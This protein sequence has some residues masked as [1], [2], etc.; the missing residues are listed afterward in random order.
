MRDEVGPELPVAD[1]SDRGDRQLSSGRGRG[2]RAKS[3]VVE[4]HESFSLTPAQRLLILDS[5][6]RS[7]LSAH[8]FGD[9]V[10]V[11]GH[12]LYAWK[13]RFDEFG[14]A[15]LE[16]HKRGAAPGSKLPELTKRAVL[17]LKKAHPDWGC[18]RISDV[19]WRSQGHAASASAIARYLKEQGYV[20]VEPPASHVH[21]PVERRFERARVNQL[22]QSDLFTF[23]L[24]RESRRL[25]LVA[26]MDDRSRFLVSWGLSASAS[27]ALV[28]EALLAGVANFG[29]PEEVLTDNG[30]QYATWR[31]KSAF[32][33]LLQS[34]GIKHVLARPRRP[35]TLGKV[36]RFWGSLW[37]E[38]LEAAVFRSLDEA[39][40]RVGLYIDHYNFHRP[41]QGL[42]GMTPADRY[43][44]AEPEVLRTLRARV[45][46]NAGELARD[47]LPR[48]AFYLT[49]RVGDAGISLHAEGER[50]VLTTDGGA[51]EEVNLAAPGRRAD[52]AEDVTELPGVVTPAA[53]E[54]QDDDNE[55][56]ADEGAGAEGDAGEDRAGYGDDGDGDI[57]VDADLEGGD[58]DGADG[59]DD[60]D[61]DP[62]L[63]GDD[64]EREFGREEGGGDRAGDAGRPAHAV[65]GLDGIGDFGRAVLPAGDARAAGAGEGA[66]AAGARPGAEHRAPAA[67]S[68]AGEDAAGA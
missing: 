48:K 45:A 59:V 68:G 25:Y 15:A 32:T 43:F 42:D 9:L 56:D 16:D 61:T 23:L 7:G 11:S 30:P 21:E 36:E 13:K 50:I 40:T 24:K 46:A 64:G 67:E 60:D 12:T 51:R 17:M 5:W 14:P 38:C 53:G 27:G 3:Q 63:D 2:R 62:A 54:V 31:G 55:G 35:Q 10:S 47:G 39:R 65:G 33:R 18:E 28:R 57:D 49:G 19:L 34:K 37:R 6:L 1:Q 29:L 44:E 4:P 8:D 52:E 20:S 41:H 66:G 58:E 26:F 22:W